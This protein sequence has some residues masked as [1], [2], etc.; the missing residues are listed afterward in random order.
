MPR[1]WKR[2]TSKASWS[3]SE[4]QEAAIHIRQ[5]VSIRKVAKETGIPFSTL[6]K[7][8]K[9]ILKIVIMLLLHWTTST[10]F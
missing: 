7:M 1:N 5:G 3:G 10:N 2:K 6:Q 4:L 9:F 8:F